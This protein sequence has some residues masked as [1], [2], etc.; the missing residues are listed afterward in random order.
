[1]SA[2]QKMVLGSI[3]DY[4]SPTPMKD[5]STENFNDFLHATQ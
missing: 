5:K 1:M 4:L 2:I 3:F